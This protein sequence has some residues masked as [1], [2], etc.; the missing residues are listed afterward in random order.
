MSE[1]YSFGYRFKNVLR[2]V[3]TLP[4]VLASVT[5]SAF[6]LTIRQDWLMAALIPLDVFFL[7]MFVNLSNDYFDHRSGVDQARFKE[8]DRAF[9]DET[10]SAIS[11]KVYWQGNAFD[12]GIISDRGGQ[13]LMAFLAAAAVLVA[14]PIILYGGWL[15]IVLGAVGFFL[16]FFYTAP[17]INLGARG[18][19][20]VDV[21]ISF[22]FLSFFTFFV[23]VGQFSVPMLI[24]AITVG[25]NVANMRIVDEMSGR[26]A[27]LAAG[28]TD[29]VVRFGVDGARRIMTGFMVT[30]YTLSAVLMFYS[31]TFAI[32]FLSVPT[33]YRAIRTL[34]QKKDEFWMVKPVLDI[35]KIAV[36]HSLLVVIALTLQSVLT[37]A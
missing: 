28:E 17:P 11:K 16:S 37:S 24:I 23:I 32:L 19:G 35:M 25:L 3:Y 6:A 34:G 13:L 15:V 36:T 33:A 18:L 22:A 29:L 20:E 14:I 21:F 7:A 27:H 5:G 2:V 1:V 10:A 9:N 26:E 12:R 30:A 4:F 8:T 31:W